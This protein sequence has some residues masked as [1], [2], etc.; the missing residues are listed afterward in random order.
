MRKE[1]QM[2]FAV[3]STLLYITVSFLSAYVEE[4]LNEIGDLMWPDGGS[5]PACICHDKCAGVVWN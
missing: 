3:E 5:T 1:H 2:L 4:L